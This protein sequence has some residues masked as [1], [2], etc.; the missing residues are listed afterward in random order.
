[1]RHRRARHI[2][3][4][5]V[6]AD[7]RRAAPIYVVTVLHVAERAGQVGPA[8]DA[9]LAVH[10]GEMRVDRA[11][12]QPEPVADVAAA[13][14]GGGQQRHLAL[15]GGERLDPLAPGQC[16][17]VQPAG[18]LG[19]LGGTLL[20]GGR[21]PRLGPRPV[22]VGELG[23]R[24][25]GEHEHVDRLV[26]VDHVALGLHVALDERSGVGGV[27]RGER[28]VDAAGERLEPVDDL[29][30]RAE[31]DEVV[32]QCG[33]EDVHAV[34]AIPGTMSR[35]CWRA[36]A[37]SPRHA[38]SHARARSR[39]PNDVATGLSPALVGERRAP[40]PPAPHWPSSR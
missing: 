30:R 13:A 10:A 22:H 12:R 20:G 29:V 19:E 17:R 24:L 7:R 31:P 2:W 40:P 34:L 1:M 35:I 11:R 16:G 28:S 8:G 21:Q 32:Q 26:A 37:R 33:L 4:D 6:V 9:Q 39:V 36:E 25:G 15:A 18:P 23:R 14:P 3:S 38:S 5:Y 27:D